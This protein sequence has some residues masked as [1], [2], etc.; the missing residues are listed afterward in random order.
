MPATIV[1]TA[2]RLGLTTIALSL[3][4]C[5]ANDPGTAP[6]ASPSSAAAPVPAPGA[7]PPTPVAAA[8][9]VAP[10]AA[11][12]QPAAPQSAAP[13]GVTPAML[14]QG[15][16]LFTNFACGSCHVLGDAGA[17]GH[18]G[19][20]LDG[21]PNLSHALVVDRVANG[22]GAMP[23]FAGQLNEQEIATLASY[24]VKVAAK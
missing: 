18:V 13:A 12:P 20:A 22:Q 10:S 9:A 19:P 8:P 21:N 11:A 4:S 1:S 16:D 2:A 24:V 7:A 14:D 3:A 15:R 17:T 6:V 23:A 5:A